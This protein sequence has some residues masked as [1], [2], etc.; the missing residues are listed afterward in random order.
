MFDSTVLESV[1]EHAA[2]LG[3][4]SIEGLALADDDGG[5]HL[6]DLIGA[7][8]DLTSAA[9]AL[10]ARAAVQLDQVRRAEEAEAEVPVARRGAGVAAEVGLAARVSGHQGRTLLG[11]GRVL[12]TEMPHTLAALA[13]GRLSQWRAMLLVR[14]S[15]CLRIEDRQRLDAELCADP[16][17]L[18]GLGDRG[19][20]AAAR[21][22]CAS[23][24]PA[25]VVERKARAEAER[26]VTMRP[27][28][29]TMVYL[30]AL[31]PVVQGVAV[32]KA[33]QMRAD[34]ARAA[35]DPRTRGQ[36][37]ADGLVS[38][39]T[40]LADG[41]QPPVLVNLVMTDR[42]LFSGEG[43]PAMLPGYGPVPAATACELVGAD[44]WLRRLYTVPGT[45]ALVAMDSRS[46]KVRKGLA[47][48]VRIRDGATCRVPWCDAPG[49]HVDHAKAIAEGGVTEAR[50]LQL[51]CEG[52][53]YAKQAW[54]WSARHHI[55]T[56]T[57][58]GRFYTSAAPPVPD[59]IPAR[60][61]ARWS[62]GERLL[63]EMLGLAA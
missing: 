1:R 61:P 4:A 41:E 11:F 47:E 48:F 9:A 49:R 34:S 45:G 53:N 36:V 46:R 26:S 14:E 29:D 39:V 51:T 57:P 22:W 44:S 8:E 59:G 3:R 54:G 52:H 10:S 27:A 20:A 25:S 32:Y 62:P 15:A 43:E 55:V 12:C 6:V 17:V 33:L 19:V 60:A 7:L 21:R 31:L 30:T 13:Q 24:D 5:A 2:S 40:G 37:M 38:A 16:R 56:R 58:T 50:S 35:G 23:E 63:V 28:P 18:R 42:A